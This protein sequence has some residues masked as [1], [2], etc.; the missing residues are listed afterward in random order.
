MTVTSCQYCT[1]PTPVP[2][3]NISAN[4]VLS[5]VSTLLKHSLLTG[6]LYEPELTVVVMVV[7]AA[8]V[9]VVIVVADN[10]RRNNKAG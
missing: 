5:I 9:V 8:A 2:S 6:I 10:S 1:A 3:S 7:V 4:Y